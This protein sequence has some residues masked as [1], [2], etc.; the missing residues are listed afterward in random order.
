VSFDI[1]LQA[2]ENGDAASR[3]GAAVRQRLL[4]VAQCYEPEFERVVI[5]GDLESTDVYGVPPE[6]APLDSLVFSRAGPR[7]LDL[8]VEVA[9]MADL[10]IIPP[11]CPV[12]IVHDGQRR[13]LP[14]ELAE[15]GVELV[16]TGRALLEVFERC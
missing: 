9:Q 2:F 6:N 14:P 8:L 15:A 16:T 4:G 1:H 13:H 10:V 5:R 3:D 12:C 7:G 11:G